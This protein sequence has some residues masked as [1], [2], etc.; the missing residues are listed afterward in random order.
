M[1]EHLRNRKPRVAILGTYLALYDKAF[2]DYRDTMV[3]FARDIAEDLSDG[4]AVDS[5]GI[6]T[7]EEEAAQFVREAEKAEVD[8]LLILSLGY[9]NS[10]SVADPLIKTGL[11]IVFLNTQMIEEIAREYDYDTLRDNHGMQGIQ[12][13]TAVLVRAGRSF[14]IVT[15]LVNQPETRAD[16]LDQL[17]AARAVRYLRKSVV[18]RMGPPQP[19]MGDGL[20]DQHLL[21]SRFGMKVL[22]L[23]PELLVEAAK[24]ATDADIEA[25]R[26]FDEEHFDIDPKI[27]RED[28]ER[29][30]RL[31]VGLRKLVEEFHLSGLTLSFDSIVEVPGIET[32]PFLGITKLMGE[33]MAYGGEGDLLVTAGG[34]ITRLLCGETNFTEMYTMDFKRNAVLDTHMAEGNWRMARKDRKPRLLL[35]EF[36][37]ADCEPFAALAFSLEPGEVTL[38]DITLTPGDDGFHFITLPSRMEDFPPLDGLPIP[39]FLLGFNRDIREILNDYSLSGGTHHLSMAYGTH[40]RRF[41]YLSRYL[42]CRLTEI[43]TA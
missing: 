24:E 15:G 7:S 39:N 16:L 8:A 23:D 30:S 1:L 5:L 38:F 34:V 9:T 25:A 37:L 10:L 11:P 17:S 31:E 13:I 35:R 36:P 43:D 21:T 42:G 6:S 3:N 20:F 41:R 29:S 4:I 18:G 33:G 40:L 26:R 12:D 28:H 19:G 32:V 22:N 2:P 27:T 14:G